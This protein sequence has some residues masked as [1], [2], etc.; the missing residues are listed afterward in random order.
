MK[1]VLQII[2]SPVEEDDCGIC[3]GDGSKCR[4]KSKQFSGSFQSDE[5]QKLTL[6]P[7]GI[8]KVAIRFREVSSR[9]S[10]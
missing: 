8:R 6:L 5:S 3:G 2:G 1:F 4:E 9:S 10:K 7:R